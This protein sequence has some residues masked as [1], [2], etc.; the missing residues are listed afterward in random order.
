MLHQFVIESIEIG[1]EL[2][3]VL[4]RDDLVFGITQVTLVHEFQLLKGDGR[5]D[6]QGYGNGKL[7]HYQCLPDSTFA[8]CRPQLAFQHEDRLESG[9]HK[10][11][12]Y[13]GQQ[14]DENRK[15]HQARNQ[16]PIHQIDFQR[17]PGEIIEPG[18]GKKG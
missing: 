14:P 15:S 9:N 17:L 6:H 1:L 12:I 2:L 3:E 8:L 16:R 11:R 18:Q 13:A 7:R 5:C 10:C 4:Q